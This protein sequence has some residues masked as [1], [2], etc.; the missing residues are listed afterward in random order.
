[1]EHTIRSGNRIAFRDVAGAEH[2]SRSS[3]LHGR[4]SL[5]LLLVVSILIPLCWTSLHVPRMHVRSPLC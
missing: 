3:R 1:M 5:E 4:H 2:L